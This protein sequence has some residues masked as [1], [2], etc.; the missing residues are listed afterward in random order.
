MNV[1]LYGVIGLY[2]NWLMSAIDSQCS[3]QTSGDSNFHC[4]KSYINLYVKAFTYNSLESFSVESTVVNIYVKP[5]NFVWFLPQFFEKTY[6]V[7][8]SVE[9]LAD[10]LKNKGDKF[11]LFHN[12]K[13]DIESKYSDIT[14][15]TLVDYIFYQFLEKPTQECPK[16]DMMTV[17][18][19]KYSTV[20]SRPHYINIEYK[21]FYNKDIMVEKL[22]A[23]PNFNLEHFS[24]MYELLHVRNQRYFHVYQDFTHKLKNNLPLNPIESA[25]VWQLAN[26]L[27]GK[28]IN[29]SNQKFRDLVIAKERERLLALAEKYW[30]GV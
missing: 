15:D 24:K 22:Q 23:L 6:G 30:S 26:R 10:D 11:F 27:Y 7:G 16:P 28:T 13:K 8:I 3:V 21:D 20:I 5:E 18:M 25:Y 14:Y 17:D 12:I 29:W 19:V 1:S 2:Q 9:S 4:R